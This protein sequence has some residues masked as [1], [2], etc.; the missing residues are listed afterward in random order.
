MGRR[1]EYWR[2]LRTDDGAVF[3]TEVFLDAGLLSP[4]V[5]WAP[6]PARGAS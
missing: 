2:Q 3:D 1:V 5:T 6:T 4:F